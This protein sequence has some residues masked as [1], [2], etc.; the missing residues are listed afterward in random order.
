MHAHC[1]SLLQ[2]ELLMNLRT[3]HQMF[4]WNGKGNR[5]WRSVLIKNRPSS[6]DWLAIKHEALVFCLF[7]LLLIFFC[8]AK[9]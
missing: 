5:H 3:V 1:S 4:L 9:G 2:K 6:E 8:S 7:A